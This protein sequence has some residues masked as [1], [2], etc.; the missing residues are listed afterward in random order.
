MI[1]PLPATIPCLQACDLPKFC[2]GLSNRARR[3]D[4][5]P[6][7]LPWI[8][9]AP[10]P[11]LEPPAADPPRYKVHEPGGN[12]RCASSV[13]PANHLS[14]SHSPAGSHLPARSPLVP[15]SPPPTFRLASMA[16][17]DLEHPLTALLK[18][19]AGHDLASSIWAPKP[20]PAQP[21]WLPAASNGAY[22]VR[23]ENAAAA[24]P[25]H[26][27]TLMH[28][29]PGLSFGSYEPSPIDYRSDPFASRAAPA[30]DHGFVRASALVKKDPGTIGDGRQRVTSVQ[31]ESDVGVDS[32]L[33]GG[34]AD[35]YMRHSTSS[36]SSGH[37]TST[38]R[39][40]RSSARSLA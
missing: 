13:P 35:A 18:P 20:L 4:F 34:R 31:H 21:S 9:P 38:R 12:S 26:G 8:H 25:E 1:L 11:P 7:F 36:S 22:T 32:C 29:E 10:H 37:S 19:P 17:S 15:F 14:S 5:S 16:A 2:E 40:C 6:N 30:L 3:S 24:R 33:F 23:D 28:A 39:C 27:R